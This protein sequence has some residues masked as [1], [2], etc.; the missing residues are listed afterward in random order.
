MPYCTKKKQ[1][2]STENNSPVDPKMSSNPI[3]NNDK[4]SRNYK[5]LENYSEY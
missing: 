5:K 1:G 3:N 4:T 2:M